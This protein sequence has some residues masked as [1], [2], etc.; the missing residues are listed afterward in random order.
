MIKEKEIKNTIEFSG[1]KF[2]KSKY[3]IDLK[4][5]INDSMPSK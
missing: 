5:I 2:I 4:G 3:G 1:F